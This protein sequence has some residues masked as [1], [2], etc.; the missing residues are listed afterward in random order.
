M[1]GILTRSSE[2]FTETTFIFPLGGQFLLD[3]DEVNGWGPIGPYDDTN[4]QD[5][6][7]AGV[8]TPNRVSGGLCF[9]F[10]VK[11][12]RFYVWHQNSSASAEAWGWRLFT[13]QKVDGSN[14]VTSI[15]M[16]NEVSEGGGVGPRN[17]LSTVTQLTDIT[18]TENNTLTAGHVLGL[19]VSSPTAV[20]TNYYVRLMSGYIE[21]ERIQY[22]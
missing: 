20:T 14:V 21:F 19:G 13:Q 6:G 4:N 9:P 22:E 1:G 10:D 5:L 15:D 8:V 18:F 11:I 17:Y 16:V 2:G 12:K 3:S 7:D